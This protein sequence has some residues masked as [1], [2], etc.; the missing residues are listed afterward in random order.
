MLMLFGCVL[1]FIP[2]AAT[3]T[4]RVVVFVYTALRLFTML[5]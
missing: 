4:W 1:I 3:V 5:R 2:G